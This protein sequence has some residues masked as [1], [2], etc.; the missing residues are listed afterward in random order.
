MY[1]SIHASIHASIHPSIQPYEHTY[2]PGLSTVSFFL[3]YPGKQ[4]APYKCPVSQ[5]PLASWASFSLAAAFELFKLRKAHGMELLSDEEQVW[6]KDVLTG[7]GYEVEV[8]LLSQFSQRGEA[9]LSDS[10]SEPLS[11]VD[12]WEIV[13]KFVKHDVSVQN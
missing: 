7:L 3:S 2:H 4:T 5:G 1:P 8:E 11:L 10:S 12:D 13:C 9:A 6:A